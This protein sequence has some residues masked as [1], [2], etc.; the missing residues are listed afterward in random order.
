MW[1]LLR[2][3]EKKKTKRRN[4][5]EREGKKGKRPLS[6]GAISLVAGSPSSQSCAQVLLSYRVINRKRG[7]HNVRGRYNFLRV[8]IFYIF[9]STSFRFFFFLILFLSFY[10]SW[11]PFFD[12]WWVKPGDC[13]TS[14]GYMAHKST[15]K[16]FTKWTSRGLINDETSIYN[17]WKKFVN[18][19]DFFGATWSCA[20]LLPPVIH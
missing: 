2:T 7:A 16:N 17:D 14:G 9:F 20:F 3:I 13:G 4:E 12:L 19:W 6:E 15:N 5:R 11:R 8:Y 18:R 1:V 10:E